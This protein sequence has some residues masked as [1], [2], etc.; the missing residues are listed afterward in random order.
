M[1][2]NGADIE[3]DK[4]EALIAY[5]SVFLGPNQP[6]LVVPININT[7]TVE[8]FRMVAP[9]ASH[10]GDIVKTRTELK[11]FD[12]PED[13]LRVKGITKEDF[14]RVRPFISVFEESK[15]R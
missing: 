6:K 10:A 8:V 1:I 14:E 12:A 15:A 9:L 11:R 7:A 4:A 2:G 13:L 5:F 3:R